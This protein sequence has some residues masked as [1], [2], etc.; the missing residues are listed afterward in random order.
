MP[1]EALAGGPHDLETI[2][3]GANASQR[4]ERSLANVL[5]D[6]A[7][8]PALQTLTAVAPASVEAWLRK[9]K[10]RSNTSG[11]ALANTKQYDAVSIVAQRVLRELRATACPARTAMGEPLRWC[12]HGGPGTGKSHVIKLIIEL[13]TTVL[14]WNMGVEFQVVALQAV[15]AEQLG[16]ARSI[17]LV[18]SP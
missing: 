2:F 16:G 9:L 8:S 17:T 18:A 1:P 11:R 14:K 5:K 4:K 12:V 13:F 6:A 10:E 3:A 15:M 7:R